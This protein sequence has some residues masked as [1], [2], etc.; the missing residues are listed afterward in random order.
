MTVQI[1]RFFF[2]GVITRVEWL[3]VALSVCVPVPVRVCVY[4]PV[5]CPVVSAR[6]SLVT[7]HDRPAIGLFSRAENRL[8]GGTP[9]RPSVRLSVRQKRG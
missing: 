4:V 6:S 8:S 1:A 7:E 3:S 5:V 9:P 2:A